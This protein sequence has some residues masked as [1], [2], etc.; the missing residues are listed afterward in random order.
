MHSLLLAAIRAYQRHVS[1]RLGAHCRFQPS[2]SEYA[3][4]AIAHH[5]A[6]AGSLLAAARLMRCTPWAAGG[7][8]PVP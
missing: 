8:D 5:G 7:A 6:I 2:C 4:I 1:P 3:A